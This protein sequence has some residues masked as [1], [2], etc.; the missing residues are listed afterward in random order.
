VNE[1]KK[2]VLNRAAEAVSPQSKQYE[3][4]SGCGLEDTW[5]DLVS[6]LYFFPWLTT[7]SVVSQGGVGRSTEY[8]STLPGGA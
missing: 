7:L 4:A 1:K 3:Q 2:I 8:P 5:L 6:R